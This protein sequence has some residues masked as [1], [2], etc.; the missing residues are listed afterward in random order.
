MWIRASSI[1]R[2]VNRTKRK[3]ELLRVPSFYF[4]EIM[5]DN[6]NQN[7]EEVMNSD[8]PVLIDFYAIDLRN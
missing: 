4:N 2:L 6:L 3:K 8:M 7:H 1:K 5:E